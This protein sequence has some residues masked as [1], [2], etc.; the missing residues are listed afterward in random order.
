MVG[1]L[2]SVENGPQRNVKLVITP[3]EVW[4][5]IATPAGRY[6][7]GTIDHYELAGLQQHDHGLVTL[8]FILADNRR[9]CFY[10]TEQKFD[11][12][13]LLDQ[14]DGTIGARRRVLAHGNF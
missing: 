14:L 10:S 13:L 7:P 5:E 9:V 4:S 12:A 8:T 3:T 2:T 11:M 6:D 1:K